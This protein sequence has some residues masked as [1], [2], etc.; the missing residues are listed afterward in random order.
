MYNTNANNLSDATL[1]MRNICKILTSWGGDALWLIK[2]SIYRRKLNKT[3]KQRHPMWDI[4][5]Q[6]PKVQ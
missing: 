1:N 3:P 4:T 2:V 6:Y 5:L